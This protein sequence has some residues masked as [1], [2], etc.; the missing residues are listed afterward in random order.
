M[1]VSNVR[2]MSKSSEV[3]GGGTSAAAPP[4]GSAK[5]SLEVVPVKEG[6]GVVPEDST[7]GRVELSF[8]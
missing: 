3:D 1:T 5:A 8:K 7:L 2:R 6:R 4:I